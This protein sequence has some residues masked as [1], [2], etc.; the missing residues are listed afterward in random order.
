VREHFD[1]KEVG[2]RRNLSF[3]VAYRAKGTGSRFSCAQVE[4]QR[5]QL[6]AELSKMNQL[7]AGN[8]K[9]IKQQDNEIQRLTIML[10]RMDDEA[11]IQRKEYDQ[12]RP[13]IPFHHV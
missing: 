13:V 12:A 5:E 10:K 2:E 7:L 4:K 8:E 1:F 11:L 9:I 6:R 3:A